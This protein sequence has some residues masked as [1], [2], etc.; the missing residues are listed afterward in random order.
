MSAR[1]EMV[2]GFW[3]D[4]TWDENRVR[5]AVEKNWITQKEFKT[6]TGIDF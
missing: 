2:K 1:F 5:S 3:D 6:I 4:G